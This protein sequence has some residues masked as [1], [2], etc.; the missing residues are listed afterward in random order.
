MPETQK[1]HE[2]WSS[3]S[4]FL[5]SA[6]GFAV[7]LGN[8]WRFPYIAGENGGGAFIAIYLVVSL[9][10]GVP[11][12]AAELLI[13]RRGKL[14]P[15]GSMRQLAENDG[16][17]RI[18]GAVGGLALIATFLILTFYSVVAGWAADYLFRSVFGGF[19]GITV[20]QSTQM[21][22]SLLASPWRLMLWQVVI[23]GLTVFIT[24][25][26]LTK[27]IE[28]ASFILMPTLL[29]ILL[30]MALFS[31]T[32]PGFAEAFDFLFTP[33]FSQVT[34]QTFLVAIGQV[35]FSVGIAMGGMMTYGA[36]MPKTIKV[37]S[38]SMIIV[39]ADTSVALIAGLAVFPIVFSFG[40]APSE[41][42]GLVFQS[43]PLAFGSMQFGGVLAI[44]FFVLLT[45]AAL[46]STIANFEPL[47][48]WA[49]ERRN[50]RRPRAALYFAL[51]ILAVGSGSVLSFNLLAD[52]HP[53][54]FIDKFSG[55]TIYA[56]TDFVASNILLPVGAFLTAIFAGW[57]LKRASLQEEMELGNSLVFR[58]WLFLIRFVAPGAIALLFIFAF[59]G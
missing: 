28:M 33:D 19:H 22:D 59:I 29:I 57:V 30:G 26:G 36:Y 55:M 16:A 18:W 39:F 49:E 13:G 45:C 21:L 37:A 9:L 56:L 38:S 7:G 5:L 35:F 14:S 2:N 41:G 54:G 23:V 27:G 50:I 34:A 25:R 10:L 11:L 3:R 32:T 52:F 43:L 42:A 8:I 47:L 4:A 44:L 6:I 20:E 12:V 15:V 48:S 53:L 17:S 24:S 46:T 40:L 51:A 58:A 31:M 1:V